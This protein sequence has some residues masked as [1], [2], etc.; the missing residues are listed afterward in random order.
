MITGQSEFYDLLSEP[1]P[2]EMEREVQKGAARLI[3]IPISEVINRMNRIFGPLG[4]SHQVISCGRDSENPEWLIA[5]VRLNVRLTDTNGEKVVTSH[6]G[7]GGV[8]IKRKKNGEPL[9]IGND[10]KGAVSDAVKKA[11]QH[12]GVGLYLARD[13]N[14]IEID[15]ASHSQPEVNTEH[16]E[17]YNGF[18]AVRET[19]TGA[20]V[21]MLKKYWDEYSGGRPTPKP[22]EFTIQELK[23]LTVE[24]LR[25]SFSGE[26]LVDTSGDDEPS[27]T[28]EASEIKQTSPKKPKKLE[29]HS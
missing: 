28:Q 23:A 10:Y 19:L 5:H 6:D 13:I 24:A 20:Q 17:A 18:K 14:A 4:W 7:F 3:Y 21:E 11:C 15:D 16:R 2:A 26:T 29:P 9:D 1:F 22:T 12:L 25:I 8:E 27:E